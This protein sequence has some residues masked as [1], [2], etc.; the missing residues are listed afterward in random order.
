MINTN[1]QDATGTW[2]SSDPTVMYINQQ[3]FGVGESQNGTTIIRYTSPTGVS[4][5]EWV[6]NVIAP[7]G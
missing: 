6:M 1:M 3:G 2:T 5:V 4:F 7:T